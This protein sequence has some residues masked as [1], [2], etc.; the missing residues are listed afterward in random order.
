M[1]TIIINHTKLRLAKVKQ[2]IRFTLPKDTIIPKIIIN[3]AK[4][5]WVISGGYHP[6]ETDAECYL[7][8]AKY[9]N[10]PFLMQITK[11][12]Q[13]KGYLTGFWLRNKEEAF[14]YLSAHELKHCWQHQ[15]PFEK[16][17]GK[18]KH[19]YSESD[20]DIYAVKKLHEWRKRKAKNLSRLSTKRY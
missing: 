16:R 15:H 5:P 9:T 4:D 3:E 2:I 7:K 12:E 6:E 18:R 1:A 11:K 20:A 19:R 10:F 13:K 17:M 14:V 8:I